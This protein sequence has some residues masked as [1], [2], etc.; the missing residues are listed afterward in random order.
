MDMAES[1]EVVH[2]G[3]NLEKHCAR[4]VFIR[5]SKIDSRGIL[6]VVGNKNF[7]TNILF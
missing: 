6:Y 7:F 5:G 2:K 4:A 1:A 3:E